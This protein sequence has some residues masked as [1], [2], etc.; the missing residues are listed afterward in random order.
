MDTK[1]CYDADGIKTVSQA[2]PIVFGRQADA[3]L[4]SH[5][6]PGPDIQVA[7]EKTPK[8]SRCKP[9]CRC[10]PSSGF[11]PGRLG[12]TSRCEIKSKRSS[13]KE[14]AGKHSISIIDET[15]FVKKGDKTPGVQRQYCGTIGKQENCIVT[16]HLTC[17]V[18]KNGD[19]TFYQIVRVPMRY[20]FFCQR[21]LSRPKRMADVLSP[22][23][24]MQT[25]RPTWIRLAKNS[26]L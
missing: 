4:F 10:V 17:A 9:E 18:K 24:K 8:R 22:T 5:L 13:P 20:V 7:P 11:S 12:I 1:H 19:L 3:E 14:H 25:N 15:S 26:S 21:I 6:H 16:V 23:N 2:V